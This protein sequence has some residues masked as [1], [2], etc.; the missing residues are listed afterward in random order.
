MNCVL[1]EDVCV[2]MLYFVFVVSVMDG[3]VLNVCVSVVVMWVNDDG[4]VM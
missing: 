1:V 4:G 2:M 3:Y